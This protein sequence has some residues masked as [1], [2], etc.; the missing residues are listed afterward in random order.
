MRSRDWT[1]F[2]VIS[3]I[4]L[5]SAVLL[6]TPAQ[7]AGNCTSL[8]GTIAGH[9]EF[10][11][12]QGPGW[13][14]WAFLTFGNDPTVLPARLVD[15]NNGV[16]DHPSHVKSD[17]TGNFAGDE[18]LTYTIDGVGSFQMSGHFLCVGSTTPAFCGFSE[19]GKINPEAG[20]GQFAGMTGNVSS[21]GS[22]VFFGPEPTED[23]PWIWIAQMTGSV[24]TA[25]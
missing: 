17:G 14:G 10:G 4:V 9:F 2:A 12:A 25:H 18:I 24:C 5:A 23:N 21:H 1:R 20:T 22:A 3:C 15:L 8:G 6:A 19:E 16:K 11:G 7:A 13:Y